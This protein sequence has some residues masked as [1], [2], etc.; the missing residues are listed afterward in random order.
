M[1]LWDR[2]VQIGRQMLREPRE[3]ASALVQLDMPRNMIFMAFLA[4]MALSVVATEPLLA[5]AATMLPGDPAMPFARAIGSTLGGLGVVWV[6]W[7]VGGLWSGKASFDNILLAFVCVEVIFVAGLIGL[8][9]LTAIMP[10]LAG[11][12]GLGFIVFWLWIFSNVVAEM[13]DFSSA[14][15]AFGL[16]ALSWVVVN[17]ASLMILNL[18]S[19]VAGGPSNV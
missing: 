4:I 19:G 6:I 13:H 15:K 5:V 3:A 12:A 2:L 10:P 7:K 9:I 16:V 11:L 8:L 18:F 1:T 14:W 17:Y